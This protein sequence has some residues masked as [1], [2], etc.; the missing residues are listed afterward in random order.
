MIEL[1]M[2]I[3]KRRE[4]LGMTQSQLAERAGYADKTM[5][6]K[7]EKGLI[8]LSQKK[9]QKIAD[10]LRTTPASLMGWDEEREA[11]ELAL[12]LLDPDLRRLILFAGGNLPQGE[13]RSKMV[14]AI[15]FTIQAMNAREE[16]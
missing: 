12:Y 8:N 9:I 11:D 13:A 1:Y 10:A 14:D 6:S 4:E 15:I 3:K 2:N 5:I 7:I 16:K